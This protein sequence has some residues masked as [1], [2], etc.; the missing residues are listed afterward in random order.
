MMNVLK[1]IGGVEFPDSLIKLGGDGNAA[2]TEGSNG[3]A[4]KVHAGPDRS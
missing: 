1:D 3:A 2:K 4:E